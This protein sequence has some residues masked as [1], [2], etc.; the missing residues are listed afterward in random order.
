MGWNYRPARGLSIELWSSCKGL[1][2]PPRGLNS[3]ASANHL[4]PGKPAHE[5]QHGGSDTVGSLPLATAVRA[6]S[7][8]RHSHGHERHGEK[9]AR[10]RKFPCTSFT[11]GEPGHTR[12]TGAYAGHARARAHGSH[13]RTSQP[14]KPT[15]PPTHGRRSRPRAHNVWRAQGRPLA[16]PLPRPLPRRPYRY[17]KRWWMRPEMRTGT[18]LPRLHH[19]YRTSLGDKVCARVSC[20]WLMFWRPS[21]LVVP[22]RSVIH[23]LCRFCWCSTTFYALHTARHPADACV[24]LGSTILR[25]RGPPQI[26]PC[27]PDVRRCLTESG[28]T[29]GLG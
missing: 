7:F 29:R 12:D 18:A 11:P 10:I 23:I 5:A 26:L 27:A 8:P 21:L 2:V 14:S 17:S 22:V 9:K 24:S 20:P 25:V 4:G 13:R 3:Y 1:S 19:P 16:Q 6:K 15:N 28:G